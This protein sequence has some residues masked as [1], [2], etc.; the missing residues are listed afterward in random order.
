MGSPFHAK[1]GGPYE[2]LKKVSDEN[3]LIATPNRRKSSQL[4][5]VNLLKPYYGHNVKAI[6]PVLMAGSPGSLGSSPDH[7][8]CLEGGRAARAR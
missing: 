5:H 2:V 6:K 4:C 3:Y 7:V 8:E 1:F